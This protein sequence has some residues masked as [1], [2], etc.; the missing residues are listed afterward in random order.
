MTTR[1]INIRKVQ[2]IGC[3]TSLTGIA[4]CVWASQPWHV[5]LLFGIVA[6]IVPVTPSLLKILCKFHASFMVAQPV[7]MFLQW[8]DLCFDF[9]VRQI[10]SWEVASNRLPEWAVLSRAY[11]RCRW[12][13]GWGWLPA[14]HWQ[15]DGDNAT[16]LSFS[17]H[18]FHYEIK[19]NYIT[20]K[21]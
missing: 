6:G 16:A 17:A 10:I 14:P 18:R 21:V 15:P 9:S 2:F 4:F 13:L 11:V 12:L 8:T 3:V 5:I 7:E 20:R 1:L 19:D